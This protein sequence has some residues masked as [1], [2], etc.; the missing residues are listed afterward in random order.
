MTKEQKQIYKWLLSKSSYLKKSAS[1][2]FIANIGSPNG[3][4]Q[5]YEIALKQARKD[6]K[7]PSLEEYHDAPIKINSFKDTVW[8]KKLAAVNKTKVD[9]INSSN[10]NRD[11]PGTY[12]ITG[13]A[14]APWQNKK[15]YDAVFNYLNK[16][17]ELQGIILAGDIVDLNSLSS[18]DKGKIPI[19]GVDLNW[20]YQEANKFLDQIDQLKVNG[21]KDYIYGN[22]EDRYKRISKDSDIAKFGSALTS[23]TIGLHLEKRG[24]NVFEDWK[25]DAIHL[26]KHLDICH[27]EFF[28]V[29]SAKKTID[30][31]RKSVLYF[32]T[33]R[34]QVYVEGLVGGW[35]MGFGADINAPVFN[36]A[37]RAMKNSWVN[38]SCLV[39]LDE[40]G[41]YHVEPLMFI[42]NKLIVNGRKY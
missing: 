18:H 2:L 3:S 29:H 33:H 16:E 10:S 22:H 30:T 37:S 26:G 5:D 6:H 41:Y 42:D 1:W 25:N 36:F 23:P 12:F 15:M 9:I 20:E 13:C 24:Y 40:D 38:A 35:N 14:H 28:N 19:K 7:K 32:H 17:I 11:I 31:Y 27:G 8:G 39:T 4:M 34:F 21:T